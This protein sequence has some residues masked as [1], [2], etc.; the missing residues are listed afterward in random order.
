LARLRLQD[1]N[2]VSEIRTPSRLVARGPRQLTKVVLFPVRFLFTAET[3]HVGTNAVAAEHY[4]SSV[5][6]PSARL[7][8]SAL[9]WRD[10]P[11]AHDEAIALV[12]SGL[13]PLY[14][15][16]LDDHIA[17]LDAV[18]RYRLADSFRNWRTQ[19]LE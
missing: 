2:L 11:P 15:H 13:V 9:A 1:L 3:G 17:R 5:H 8:A 12:A 16:Y 10:Q 7:V 18:H 6:A 14:I 19:L 4:L